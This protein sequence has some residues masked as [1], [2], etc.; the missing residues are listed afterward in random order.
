MALKEEAKTTVYISLSESIRIAVHGNAKAGKTCLVKYYLGI[1]FFSIMY[2]ETEE[3]VYQ[4]A[5]EMPSQDKIIP[6]SI[7]DTGSVVQSRRTLADAYMICVAWDD[8]LGI[9]SI[10][11]WVQKIR[12]NA[13][14]DEVPVVLV[15][16]KRDLA[17]ATGVEQK[18]EELKVEQE[19]FG[20][21]GVFQTSVFLCQENIEEVQRVFLE[22]L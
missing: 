10:G 4:T 18:L 11:T 22:T 6:L 2:E 15:L 1:P 16:T 20:L 13:S 9:A 21:Q 19:R 14:S 3:E 8:P 5:V 17:S 7:H 12:A